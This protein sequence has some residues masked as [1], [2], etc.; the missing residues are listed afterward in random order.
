MDC[1]YLRYE[2]DDGEPSLV[3]FPSELWIHPEEAIRKIATLGLG[4]SVG[5][6]CSSRDVGDKE[7]LRRK[8]DHVVDH[9]CGQEFKSGVEARARHFR[10]AYTRVIERYDGV[11]RSIVDEPPMVVLLMDL[12]RNGLT[13]GRIAEYT[14][15]DVVGFFEG[16]V[17]LDAEDA[18]RLA[19]A[20]GTDARTWM[21][22]QAFDELDEAEASKIDLPSPMPDLKP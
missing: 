4:G 13:P 12:Q 21:W 11:L 17:R 7:E 20:T 22:A 8:L 19:A 3:E 6:W 2:S 18:L 15:I 10:A 5:V 14:G 1:Y 9:V 16:C